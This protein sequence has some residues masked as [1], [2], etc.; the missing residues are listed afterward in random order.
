MIVAVG[1]ILFDKFPDYQRIGGAPF[2]F[3]YHLKSL[4]CEVRFISRIGNDENGRTILELLQEE[5]F[6]TD[7]IQVDK[8]HRTGEVLIRLETNGNARFDILP[9][10][11]Y[12]YI[13]C[14][15]SIKLILN[16]AELLYFPAFF[17]TMFL[18]FWEI[19]ET[20]FAF[21]DAHSLTIR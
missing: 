15:R 4:G 14:D 12:D 3:A 10:V 7:Y 13:Q 11:A 8:I 19:S 16:Q 21:S 20:V 17:W 6:H 5:Q 1:E 9:D 2:N 18:T